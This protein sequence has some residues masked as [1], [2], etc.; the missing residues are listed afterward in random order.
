[1][2]NQH[3]N[4]TNPSERRRYTRIDSNLSINIRNGNFDIVTETKN[5]SCIGA[6]CQVDRYVPLLT[7]LK[8][9]ILIPTKTKDNSKHID[10][11]GIVV[12]I[13]KLNHPLEELYNIAIYFNEIKKDDL[14][15]IESFVKEQAQYKSLTSA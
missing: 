9:S 2:N 1:M 8:T 4:D 5:I 6:Y 11:G 15:K 7:K 10:C 13:E 12:R 3:S 14:N